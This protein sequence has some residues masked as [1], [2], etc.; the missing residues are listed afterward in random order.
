MTGLINLL[1][2]PVEITGAY[3]ERCCCYRG[4]V[5]LPVIDSTGRNVAPQNI[6][7]T[8]AI[9]VVIADHLP[10]EIADAC[11]VFLCR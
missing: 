2:P 7:L 5:H 8:V 1:D 3:N 4:A 6:G 9:V 11:G 10:I